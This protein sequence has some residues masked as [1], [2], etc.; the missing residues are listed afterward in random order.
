MN[1]TLGGVILMT[2]LLGLYT[3]LLGQKAVLLLLSGIPVG[4]ALGVALLFMPLI[5]VWAIWRELSF[6]VQSNRLYRELTE[7]EE[8][9]TTHPDET[10]DE[11]VGLPRQT[12]PTLPSGRVDRAAAKKAFPLY[13]EAAECNPQDW[14]VWFRLGLIYDACGDRRRARQTIRRAIELR[15]RFPITP[16]LEVERGYTP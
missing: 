8:R 3:L 15:S 14:S 4:V 16:F 12:L 7:R 1:R 9:E 11:R 13:Q 5:M 10:G 2:A 6:G